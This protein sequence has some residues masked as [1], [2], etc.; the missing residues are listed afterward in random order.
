MDNSYQNAKNYARWAEAAEKKGDFSKA[1]EYFIEAAGYADKI[2]KDTKYS[3]SLRDEC[4]KLR[5]KYIS[6]A[7]EMEAPKKVSSNG[8]ENGAND[9]KKKFSASGKSDVKFSDVAGLQDVKDQIRYNVIEPLKNPALAEAYG[10]APGAKIMLYGPPGTG[11]TFVARAIAGEINAEFFAINCQDLISKYIGE[12]S[13]QL[14]ALFDEAESHKRAI[15]FFD[16]FDSVASKRSD[17]T[18]GADAEIS[19]FVATFLT[20][21]DGFKKSETNEMLLLIAATNRPW[22]I[23]SAML[24][25]GRFDTHIYVGVPDQEAREFMVKSALGASPMEDDVD[26]RYIAKRLDGFGGG[27]IKALCE[28]IKQRAYMRAVKTNSISPI[29]LNDCEDIINGAHNVITSEELDKFDAF[30]TNGQL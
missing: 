22:A 20:R 17:N 14:E 10:I 13:Q 15:I 21:V 27:D 9:D 25:G 28:K 2:T 11:K 26:L 1:K 24:R 5:D 8:T 19:R 30:R 29:T 7:N 18:D 12:S 6:L 4:R 16:E 23:D 3:V